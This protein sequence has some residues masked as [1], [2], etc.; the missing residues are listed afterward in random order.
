MICLILILSVRPGLSWMVTVSL[1]WTC[2]ILYGP[3]VLL[4]DFLGFHYFLSTICC[5]ALSWPLLFWFSLM[6]FSW[7]ICSLI[8]VMAC[9]STINGMLRNMSLLN[10]RLPGLLP[11]V[12]CT[13][14]CMVCI[15][16]DNASSKYC[17]AL[18]MFCGGSPCNSV[19]RHFTCLVHFFTHSIRL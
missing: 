5:G 7:I 2:T 3:L 8:C 11:K 16:I 13:P 1:T 12:E 18:A 15:A 9:Q 6:R 17:A 14:A 10:T 19:L 4:P